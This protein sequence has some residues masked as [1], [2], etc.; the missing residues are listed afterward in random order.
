MIPFKRNAVTENAS[1]L[2]LLEYMACEKPVISTRLK[3]ITEV[4]GDIVLYADS[5]EEM[6]SHAKMLESSDVGKELGN[7]GRQ[8]VLD[9]YDWE[10]I[11][12]KLDEVLEG[13]VDTN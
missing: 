12:T 6:I 10:N 3:G 4:A 8:L 7:K 9:K 1:P 5:A 13:A 11:A 2:K